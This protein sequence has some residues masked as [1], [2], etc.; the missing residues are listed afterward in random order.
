VTRLLSVVALALVTAAACGDNKDRV[1]ITLFAAAPDAIEMGDSTKLL[2]AIDPPNAK[3]TIS[4]V[5]DVSGKNEAPVTPSATTEYKLTAT[6]GKATAEATVTVTVGPRTAVGLKIEAANATPTAGD[7]VMVMV[8]AL[9]PNGMPAVGFRG[10]VKVTS[11]DAQAVLPPDLVFTAADAGVKVASVTLKTAGVESLVATDVARP[12]QGSTTVTVVPGAAASYQ[13]SALPGSAIAGEAL[14]LTITARDMFGNVATGYAGMTILTS[15]DATDILPGAGTFTA[16]VRTVSLTFVKSG[17]HL[18]TVSDVAGA[19]TAVDTTSVTIGAASPFD[20]EVAQTNVATIAGSPEGFT[21]KIVD[22]FGNT[23]DNFTGTVHFTSSDSAATLPPDY[24]FTAVD[25]GSHA[26]SAT[27]Q[28][29]GIETVTI[30]DTRGSANGLASWIV[31][32]AGV[33]TCV[34]SQ[35]PGSATAGSVVGLMVTMRDAFGNLATS[36]AGTVHLTASDPRAVLPPD[37]T[38]GVADAGSHAFSASLLT[39]GNQTVTAT[40]TADASITC[41]TAIAVTPAAPKIVLGLPGDANA[42]YAVA[43]D[44]AIKDVFDNP[45]PTFAG[46]V[47]FTSTDAGTGAVTPA[48]ITFTGAEGGVATTNATFVTIGNQTIGATGAGIGSAACAV[49]GLVYTGPTVGRV[50]LVASATSTTNTV[51]LDLIANERLEISSFFGGGPG[52]F[53]VGMN[54]PIDTTRATGDAVLLTVGTALNVNQPSPNPPIVPISAAAIGATDHV[55]YTAVSRR[56]TPTPAVFNQSTEVQAGG[57]FYSVRL[58]LTATGTVGPVFDGAQLGTLFR[59]A[60]RDQYGDDFVN[61]GEF[62]LGKL[63]IR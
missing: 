50:R 19:L 21:T 42:G 60:I 53:A 13:L 57:V 39:T 44:V 1:T 28:T 45:I 25:A 6:R 18:A 27:L 34:A 46:T 15:T 17:S 56:R 2:F 36:Y 11:S 30:A 12:T 52:S 7:A 32:A 49:H 48:A 38:Y 5:G 4:D 51:Q 37:V 61:A 55:L 3:V 40:D 23:C 26:F 16:G 35:A 33:A 29:A 54:L 8:T 41:S 24:T 47:S 14:V 58:K 43:V 62:G 9:A 63:E 20:I 59:A 31:G 10:T 22:R